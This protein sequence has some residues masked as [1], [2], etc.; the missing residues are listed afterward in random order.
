MPIYINA[1]YFVS[2]EY[3]GPLD[4]NHSRKEKSQYRYAITFKF[5]FERF[6]YIQFRRNI[7]IAKKIEREREKILS[8][9]MLSS[10]M[11]RSDTHLHTILSAYT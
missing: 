10:S 11:A 6:S 8:I 7:N 4:G 5:I 9:Y 1:Y 3:L 2:V